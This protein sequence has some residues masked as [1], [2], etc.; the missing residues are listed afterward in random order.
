MQTQAARA[1]SPS[2]APSPDALQQE[3]ES[4]FRL[5]ADSAPVMI[6]LA[7]PDKQFEWFNR[8]W[9]EFTGRTMEQERGAGWLDSVHIEDLERCAGIYHTSFDARQR[10]TMDFRMR[11]HDGSYRWI[12]ATGVPRH[13][14]LLYTSPSPRD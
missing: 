9:L 5:V 10:F 8:T 7:G 6:W 1:I 3:S 12:M 13:S 14:C 4:R 11:R 2:S